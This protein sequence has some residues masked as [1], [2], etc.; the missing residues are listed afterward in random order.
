MTWYSYD[1]YYFQNYVESGTG[2]TLT[3][4]S[5]SYTLGWD[6]AAED[7]VAGIGWNP[8]AERQG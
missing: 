4:N 3:L 6:S 1:G 2:A 7:V 8:G 5:N